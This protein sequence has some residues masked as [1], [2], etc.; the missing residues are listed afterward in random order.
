MPGV[1]ETLASSGLVI[2]SSMSRAVA[3]GYC[4]E[5]DRNGAEKP[6][7]IRSSGMRASAMAPS[8]I[9]DASTIII[10]TGRR[11]DSRTIALSDTPGIISVAQIFVALGGEL[12]G[13]Q[14]RKLL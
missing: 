8:T 3:S 6:E 5:T 1:V 4:T 11:S 14:M 13:L 7:G 9:I 2:F 10:A 12:L